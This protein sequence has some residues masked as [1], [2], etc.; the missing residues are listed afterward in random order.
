MN[1][2]ANMVLLFVMGALAATAAS[3]QEIAAPD[4]SR[5]QAMS[6]E[7]ISTYREQIQRRIEGLG[8]AEQR[9]MRETSVNGRSQLAQPGG[10][11]GY[12]QGYGSRNGQGSNYG[13]GGGDGRG[14]HRR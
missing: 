9:L 6:H 14:G 12:G 4:R 3:A 8:E 5:L 2:A 10:G 11:G 13:R 7:E 1:A